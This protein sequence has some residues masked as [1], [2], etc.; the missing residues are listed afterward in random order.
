MPVQK[1]ARTPLRALLLIALMPII[2]RVSAQEP[3]IHDHPI[4]SFVLVDQLEYGFPKDTNGLRFNGL[5][6]IGGDYNRLW[7]NTE[8]TKASKGPLEDTDVQLL[9][10]RLI[11]PFWDL[12]GGVRYFRP[13]A[14]APSRGSAVFGITG[15]APYRFEVQGA[16]FISNKGEVSGRVELEYELYMS[17]RLVAQPRFE[18]NVAVQRVPE[19]GIGRGI[20]DA[21]LGLRLRYE[22][23]REFAPYVGVSWTNRFFETADFARARGDNVRSL[24]LVVGI[25]MWR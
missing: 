23:K 24:G 10:G 9:Y 18:T 1:M 3:P 17:Q 25:R 12:Q 4:R 19:L 21:E 7:I 14:N 8:G 5:S 15:L 22:F 11:A 2:N 16:S 6:W 20:N 13:R